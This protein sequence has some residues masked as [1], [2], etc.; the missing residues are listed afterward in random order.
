MSDEHRVHLREVVSS[1]ERLGAG[2]VLSL[3]TSVGYASV[4]TLRNLIEP[5]TSA[6]VRVRMGSSITRKK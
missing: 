3:D 1:T 2:P 5:C 4:L 6:S